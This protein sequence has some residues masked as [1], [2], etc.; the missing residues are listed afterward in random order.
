MKLK[1]SPL[2]L[3]YT[4]MIIFMVDA[5]PLILYT[6]IIK[7]IANLYNEHVTDMVSPVFGNYAVFLDSLFVISMVL[8]SVS[9][10]FFLLAWT[11][12]SKAGKK[13]SIPTRVLPLILFIFSYS[14]LGVSGL[15]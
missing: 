3:Y 13:L 10:V 5:V 8:T 11:G 7:P 14:L 1:M 15:A 9:L 4:S 2:G 6:L 12:A